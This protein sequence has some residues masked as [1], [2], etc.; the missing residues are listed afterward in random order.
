MT[1][2]VYVLDKDGHPLMPTRRYGWVRRALN[3]GRAVPVHTKPFTIRLTYVPKT[4]ETQPVSIDIDPG[5]TNIGITA[6]RSDGTCLFRAKAITRNKDIPKLMGQRK[7]HRQ[8]SRRGERLVRKRLAKKNGTTKEFP[9]G[10]TLP[11]YKSPVMLKNI[12]NTESRFSNRKRHDG[13]LTPTARQLLLSHENLVT[14]VRKILPIASAGIEVNKFDFVRMDSPGI[15]KIEYGKGQL[16]R[17]G[18]SVEIAVKVLQHGR[19][20]L[21]GKEEIDHCHHIVPRSRGG[22]DTLPN[23][24][25]LC[26][27]C[28]SKVHTS[29]DTLKKLSEVK[30]GVNKKYGAL[31]VLN[32]ICGRFI[33]WCA[34]VFP[35]RTNI[36]IGN[37]TKMFRDNFGFTKDHDI[38]AYCIGC[39]THGYRPMKEIPPVYEIMQYRRHDR[40]NIKAQIYRSYYLD[41]KKVAQ[42]R[43]P[44]YEANVAKD[45]KVVYKKQKYPSLADWFLDAEKQYGAKETERMRSRLIAKSSYRRYN[46]RSRKLPG[47]V[48]F[49]KGKRHIMSGQLTNG[50]YLRAEGD[51]KTNYP[52]K[53]CLITCNTGMVFL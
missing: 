26:K 20:L 30:A 14:F 27:A 44:A 4:H 10:R 50:A 46:D 29:K 13:W 40:A 42:N 31:S 39:V 15:Q 24:A 53:D 41:E 9:N 18:G 32:Q 21:C 11:G 8:A 37:D 22:S 2:Y 34:D 35:G 17:Y 6:I 33:E 3:A 47:A 49:Y 36:C 5:R 45:G 1:H 16:Y 43:K 38:D 52:A 28:H 19:C 48:F 23:I 12:T 25:G 7:T 51:N